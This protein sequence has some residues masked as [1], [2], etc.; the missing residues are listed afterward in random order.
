MGCCH[1]DKKKTSTIGNVFQNILDESNRKPNKIW[2]DKSSEFYNRSL[3]S[4]LQDNDMEM[5]QHIVK[6]HLLL[7]KDLL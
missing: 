7:P 4:W 3:K 5:Y 2:V 1:K 6:G